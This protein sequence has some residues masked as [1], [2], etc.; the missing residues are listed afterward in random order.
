ML[1]VFSEPNRI[2]RPCSNIVD[3]PFEIPLDIIRVDSLIVLKSDDYIS[4][5]FFTN[6]RKNLFINM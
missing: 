1:S 4:V 3:Q 2:W 5:I 6:I